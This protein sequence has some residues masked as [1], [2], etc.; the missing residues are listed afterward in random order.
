MKILLA[1]DSD[2]VR[3]LFEGALRSTG[4]EVM[5]VADGTAAWAA[6]ERCEP[7]IVILDWQMPGMDGMEVCRR[8]R[9]HAASDTTFVLMVSARSAG[10]DLAQA[11]AAGVDDFVTKPVTPATLRARLQ[12]AERVIAKSEARREAEKQLAHS[13]W[14]AGIGETTLALQHELNNPLFGL[15]AHSE[16]LIDDPALPA[17]L[18][19]DLMIVMAGARRVAEVVRRLASLEKPRSITYVADSRMID[20]SDPTIPP[21]LDGT[22]S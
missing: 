18:R 21:D 16:V 14:L 6:F 4:H 5:G 15:L 10:E 17:E 13:R 11:L 9:S 8:I 19:V 2:L 3:L 12:I 1:D 7:A 20:L 22:A